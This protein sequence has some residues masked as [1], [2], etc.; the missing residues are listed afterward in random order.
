MN[1]PLITISTMGIPVY[2]SMYG[3]YMSIFCTYGIICTG[4]YSTGFDG[5]CIYIYIRILVGFKRIYIGINN[6]TRIYLCVCTYEKYVYIYIYIWSVK[7][8]YGTCQT[9][10]DSLSLLII[11]V[12]VDVLLL[13]V[14]V[15]VAITTII[16]IIIIITIIMVHQNKKSFNLRYSTY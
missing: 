8:I 3:L 11:V 14:V 1:I 7:H 2:D 9:L 6:Y 4:I 12:V 10:H 13:V 5:I 15:V 16:I